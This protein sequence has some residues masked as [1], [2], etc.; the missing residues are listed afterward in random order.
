MVDQKEFVQLTYEALRN[1]YVF[2]NNY[3]WD[4]A[5]S[6]AIADLS[7]TMGGE[8][9]NPFKNYTWS[10]II[11]PAT[12][13]VCPDALSAWDENWMDAVS[14]NSAPRQEY[15][16]SIRGGND[17]TQ[18][19]LS[20]GYINE[21]GTLKNT[22]FKRFSGRASIDHQAKEW[23]KSGLNTA[24]SMS[25]QNY[26]MYDGTSN[27]NVWYSAQFMGPVYPVYEKDADGKD[28]LDASGKKQLD[29]GKARPKLSNFNSIATLYDDKSSTDN[30]NAS[31]RAYITLGSDK[32]NY[33]IL[34]GLKLTANLGVDYR[35]Q[36]GMS[37]YNM[38][39]G[40]Y[41]SKGGLMNKRNTRMLSYTFN[42]LLTYKK[43]FADK[44]NI[45]VLAGHESY[46]YQYNYLYGSKSGLVDGIYEL[47]PAVKVDGTGSYQN[48]YRIE[49]Y[50]ARVNYN[51]QEKY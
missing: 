25:K 41:S 23:L 7:A 19:M 4:N 13:R 31:G 40:N 15:Q 6:Q 38:N 50:L 33:G 22:N 16:L 20:F 10:T 9:Y 8:I 24:I 2:K 39:H 35:S 34:Q 27:A 47:D 29:Y 44:H 36:S 46:V 3:T 14:N 43:Q 26:S 45:D 1:G 28:L 48:N 17:K 42:Q 5:K 49:S 21:E 51:F 18:N 37:Y 32:E 12:E 11:D 30:D